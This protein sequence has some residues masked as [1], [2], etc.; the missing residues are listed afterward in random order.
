MY[1]FF[2]SPRDMIDIAGMG[3]TMKNSFF[4]G[5]EDDVGSYYV[6]QSFRHDGALFRVVLERAGNFFASDKLHEPDMVGGR[7]GTLPG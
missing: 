6:S 3:I 2:G 1:G 5:R 7:S 4:F